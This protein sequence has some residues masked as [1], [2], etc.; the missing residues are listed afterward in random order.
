MT[1][2]TCRFFPQS[3]CIM[4]PSSSRIGLYH[5]AV[6]IASANILA[7]NYCR[8]SQES[9]FPRV[10]IHFLQSDVFVRMVIFLVCPHSR[11]LPYFN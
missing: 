6:L 1:V 8:T 5:E 2:N 4:N 10:E 3:V 11:E 7:L 9:V